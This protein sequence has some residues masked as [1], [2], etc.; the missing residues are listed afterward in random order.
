MTTWFTDSRIFRSATLPP[1]SILCWSTQSGPPTPGRKQRQESL[2]MKLECKS[3]GDWRRNLMEAPKLT[4]LPINNHLYN[5]LNSSRPGNE[6]NC[7]QQTYRLQMSTPLLTSFRDTSSPLFRSFFLR[8][9]LRVALHGN[10][11]HSAQTRICCKM[12]QAL[13]IKKTTL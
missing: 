7:L 12:H 11:L 9:A 5:R 13:E 6:R 3:L 1:S 4:A 8:S 10:C 2:A